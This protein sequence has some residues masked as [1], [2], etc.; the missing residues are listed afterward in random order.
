MTKKNLK[1]NI[2][3]AINDLIK[4]GDADVEPAD[5]YIPKM[6]VIDLWDTY[7]DTFDDYVVEIIE[8]VTT[9]NLI[10]QYNEPPAEIELANLI[11]MF[12][13]L[14]LNEE[15]KDLPVKTITVQ[16][17]F[18]PR[19]FDDLEEKCKYRRQL[20]QVKYLGARVPKDG[21]VDKEVK[22]LYKHIKEYADKG[23]IMG[24]LAKLL[25]IPFAGDGGGAVVSYLI[26]TDDGVKYLED[27]KPKVCLQEGQAPNEL[28]D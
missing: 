9:K 17:N 1:Y 15:M 27:N 24:N 3:N 25:F 10:Y 26:F 8:K 23:Y 19:P 20:A 13:N 11:N 12:S 16:R 5:L 4:S 14:G 21:C 22:K 6:E 7:K 18:Y 28:E 2:G